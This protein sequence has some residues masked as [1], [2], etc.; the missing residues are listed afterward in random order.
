ML[1][2]VKSRLI[3]FI[4]YRR[5]SNR[6]FSKSI[7]VCDTYITSMNTAPAPDKITRIVEQY[8]ELNITW[9]L[10]GIGEMLNT[11][12]SNSGTE[13]FRDDRLIALLAEKDAQI[14][15]LLT[16]NSRLIDLIEKIK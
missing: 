16:Q 14:K 11:Q 12:S 10:T 15:E 3:E 6:A 9:L 8:P 5:M 4:R 13:G 1:S 7:G 2:S